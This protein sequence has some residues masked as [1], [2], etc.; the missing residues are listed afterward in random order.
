MAK[1][2]AIDATLQLDLPSFDCI[3]WCI[4]THV[5]CCSIAALAKRVLQADFAS[6]LRPTFLVIGETIYAPI[7]CR[8]I[9][10]F[11]MFNT[12]DFCADVELAISI[13]MIVVLIP[14]SLPRSCLLLDFFLPLGRNPLLH[15]SVTL[16]GSTVSFV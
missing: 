2:L 5:E 13:F 1:F 3:T 11:W 16:C 9:G 4:A 6:E 7:E 15:K 14:S 8:L 10:R 12:N